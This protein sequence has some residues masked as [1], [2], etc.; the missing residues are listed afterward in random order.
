MCLKMFVQAGMKRMNTRNEE[1][2]ISRKWPWT[3]LKGE[4]ICL[5]LFV[6]TLKYCKK[7]HM[8]CYV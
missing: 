4:C 6:L 3:L 7:Y 2:T 1:V 5:F 8:L